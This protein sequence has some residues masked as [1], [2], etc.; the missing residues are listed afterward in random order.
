MSGGPDNQAM[1][2][3]VHIVDAAHIKKHHMKK[4]ELEPHRISDNSNI[5][6]PADRMNQI[7]EQ[8]ENS[9]SNDNKDDRNP[10]QK[11][12]KGKQNNYTQEVRRENDNIPESKK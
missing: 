5:T 7:N 10:K 12:P 6:P 8:S 9:S 1:A 3:K 11:T 4:Q 2:A